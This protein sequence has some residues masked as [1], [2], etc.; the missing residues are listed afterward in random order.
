MT[1]LVIDDEQDILDLLKIALTREGLDCVTAANIGQARQILEK[2]TIDICLTDLRLP[3]GNGIEFI[4]QLQQSHPDI[5]TA[6]FSGYGSMEIA[7]EALKAGAFDFISK[8][9][10]A[11]TIRNAIHMAMKLID[12][13]PQMD[14]RMRDTLIGESTA[15]RSL[16]GNITKVA[17]S[18]APV[19]IKGE[20]G[21]GKELVARMIHAK[22]PL[23]D[24]PFVAVNCGAIPSELMESEFFGH[25]KG[26]FTGAVTNKEGLFNAARGGTL[27]L[28]E[29]ADLPLAMQVKL[30][31]ALQEKRIRPVG[32]AQE[33]HIDVRILSATHKD[34]TN[35][36]R[37][38]LFREDLFYR[39]NVI[40][41]AV[42]ALRERS[43]DIP[44][45]VDHF[46]QLITVRQQGAQITISKGAMDILL[47]YDYPG[48]VR[49]LE[50]ILEG[51]IALCEGRRIEPGDLSIANG[52]NRHLVPNNEQP[53]LT[54]N[55]SASAK[56]SDELKHRIIGAAARV[57]LDDFMA[58][59]ERD[60]INNALERSRYNKTA[61]AQ[62][63][64]IT[65]RS[66][67]YRIKKLGIE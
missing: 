4:K 19:Y 34:L 53:I 1:V 43:E 12:R 54:D 45:L 28:D 21:T 16:R 22:G 2:Q 3:D 24:G 67:R 38:G 36:V 39:L 62:Q 63:L 27:F 11:N 6:V 31:R 26:S 32:A 17:R 25:I 59:V 61:A 33:T 29:V 56:V 49:E 8:P 51:A 55:S 7:I 44:E 13:Q 64:G 15:M 10:D 5:P 58:T 35:Q 47:A 52:G 41:L 20:S 46:L 14:L 65:F 9:F 60:I 50:N 57:P 48:N 30:L 42:P 18:Q 37:L 66:L 23:A 40:E